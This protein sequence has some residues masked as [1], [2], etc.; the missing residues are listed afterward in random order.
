LRYGHG[1]AIAKDKLNLIFDT[2]AQVNGSTTRVCIIP[3][4]TPVTDQYRHIKQVF[5]HDHVS[6]QPELDREHPQQDV[7]F[8]KEDYSLC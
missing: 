6:D 3:S 5:L 4:S 8:R 2:F 1:I 7:A